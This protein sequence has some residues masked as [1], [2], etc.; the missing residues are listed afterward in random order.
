MILLDNYYSKNS[1]SY[2]YKNNSYN[3]LSFGYRLPK[4]SV[5][6]I[7]EISHLCCGCCGHDTLR[8][9][10]ILTLLKTFIA[11]SKR[12]LE[13]TLL[14]PFRNS[15]AYKFL[16]EM[17][18]KAPKSTISN[19]VSS[20]DVA[21]QIGKLPPETQFEVS[22]LALLSD[23]VSIKAP[24]VM[25]RLGK[26]FDL[27]NSY[28][29]EILNTL[30][31]YAQRYPKNTFAEI[32][33]MP[34]VVK[35]HSTHFDNNKNAEMQQ[36]IS[37]FKA[38]RE[39]YPKMSAK[40][41]KDMQFLNSKA[42]SV[43]NHPYYQ[44]H[45]KRLL[46][47]HLYSGYIENL[48]NKKLGLEINNLIS[49][50]PYGE[51][52][53]VHKFVVEFNKS[54]KSD[55]DLIE[56]FL[57]E[58]QATFEHI[59]AKSKNGSDDK[60]NGIMLCKQ[61][62]NERSDISYNLFLEVHPEMKKNLQRQ[63]NKVMTFVKHGKLLGYDDYLVDVKPVLLDAS[64]N[65]LK[66]RI[67]DLLKYREMQALSTYQ[68]AE[69]AYLRNIEEY[70]EAANRL[71]ETDKKI[72]DLMKALKALKKERRIAS[73]K[74]AESSE[75]REYTKSKLD[76]AKSNLDAATETVEADSALNDAAKAKRKKRK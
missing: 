47:N 10:D 3:T 46:V 68:K 58:L 8:A 35:Y 56:Y 44:P 48:G 4:D 70:N 14:K 40:E 7:R 53:I 30:N 36:K 18:T 66:I 22:Q 45:I 50:L 2:Q 38:L 55:I 15:D 71:I 17:S 5:E 62:N 61:C 60:S 13:N 34:E 26:Y 39:L 29:Q 72:D 25:R 33:R 69:L 63:M 41:I 32:L 23:K 1:Y 28:N 11:G 54:D 76:L 75:A 52:N 21:E 59:V 6:D 74:F 57:R 73:E 37:V 19:I 24:A 43:L 51:N 64:D 42:L 65:V 31:I 9:S 12:A 27:Y 20:P 67:K 16:K 49:R